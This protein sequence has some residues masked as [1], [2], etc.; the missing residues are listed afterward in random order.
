LTLPVRTDWLLPGPVHEVKHGQNGVGAKHAR[1]G[2]TH[3]GLDIVSHGGLEAMH[4]ALGASRLA[5]LEGALLKTFIGIGHE[6]TALC[7][8]SGATMMAVAEKA[9]HDRDSPAFPGYS[10]IPL[11]HG[12]HIVPQKQ[13]PIQR[14]GP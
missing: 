1:P 12:K 7:A 4:R 10:G 5:L 2:I 13:T 6:L 9:Y 8:W 11:V 14:I 3:H